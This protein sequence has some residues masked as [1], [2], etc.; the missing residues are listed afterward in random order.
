MSCGSIHCYHDIRGPGPGPGRPQPGRAFYRRG[1]SIRTDSATVVPTIRFEANAYHD[2]QACKAL[3]ALLFAQ[4]PAAGTS[5]PRA[6]A[7]ENGCHFFTIGADKSEESRPAADCKII[8]LRSFY[9]HLTLYCAFTGKQ[10]H[11]NG[12]GNGHCVFGRLPQ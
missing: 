1:S 5:Q 2:T 6:D 3:V 10:Q 9:L 7:G 12:A 8:I 11:D 4:L